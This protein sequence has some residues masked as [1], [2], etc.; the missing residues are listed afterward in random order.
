MDTR[1]VIGVAG[2]ILLFLFWLLVD[3]TL[4]PILLESI[5]YSYYELVVYGS[6]FV[7]ILVIV[8]IVSWSGAIPNPYSTPKNE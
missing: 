7:I 1:K 3:A 4:F 5:R 2:A 6:W 8:G